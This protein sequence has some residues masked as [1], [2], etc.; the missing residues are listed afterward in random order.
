MEENE[1]TEEENIEIEEIVEWSDS[2][3]EG[4]NADDDEDN[5]DNWSDWN[6][7]E[8]QFLY[9]S[10][11][12]FQVKNPIAILS[13]KMEGEYFEFSHD[14]NGKQIIVMKEGVIFDNV[15]HFKDILARYTIQEG[16]KLKKLKNDK[17]R[18][19]VV[20]NN[21]DCSWRLHAST[22]ADGVTFKIKKHKRSPHLC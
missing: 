2:E 6:S 18:V 11:H 10:D 12:D 5:E 22:Y 4:I 8:D 7:D 17:A 21:E 19:T 1:L 3:F 15:Q 13:E 14:N 20:C 16:I 9:E